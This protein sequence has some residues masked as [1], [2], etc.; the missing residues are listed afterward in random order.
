MAY[1]APP[2]AWAPPPAGAGAASE[3]AQLDALK[4]LLRQLAAQ[5]AQQGAA[6]GPQ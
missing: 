5:Q 6:G 3:P 2:V 1:A 4:D